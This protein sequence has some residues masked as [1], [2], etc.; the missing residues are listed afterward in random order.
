MDFRE[1]SN[2]DRQ[3]EYRTFFSLTDYVEDD[4]KLYF[5]NTNYN[6]L[7]IVDKATWTVERLIPFEGEERD[8]KN[9]HLYCI[10]K[11]GKIC[12]LPAE[13][14][15]AHIYDIEKGEQSTCDT[16]NESM[17]EEAQGAW[18][19]FVYGDKIYLLP[20]VAGQK[21]HLWDVQ[22][23]SFKRE[24]WWDIPLENAALAHD[25][26]D[27]KCFYSFVKESNQLYITDLLNQS[28]EEYF[29]P[30]EHI[31]Y[32]TYDGQNFWYVTTDTPDIVC[33]NRRDGEVDRYPIQGDIQWEYNII[34]CIGICYAEGNLFLLFYNMQIAYALCVLNIAERRVKNI[35]SIE[36]KRGEFGD[37]ELEPGFKKVGNELVCLL[38]NAGEVVH[39]DLET[40]ESRQYVEDFRFGVQVQRYVYDILIDKGALLY[41]EPG[42]VDLS[43]LIQHY[44]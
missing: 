9:L 12:F 43:T 33:W 27:E 41:E 14:H 34:P 22:A 38:K 6:A 16:L 18:N 40:L 29:L 11:A 26:M 24:N 32:V 4:K 36:C 8:A 30:D 15:C 3:I 20:G 7:V 39:I 42:V 28:I 19:Y 10:K 44:K 5:S 37:I 17:T 31:K 1:A 13:A 23:N 21:L 25:S 35:Y 2:R